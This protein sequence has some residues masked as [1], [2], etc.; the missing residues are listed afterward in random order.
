MRKVLFIIVLALAGL[1]PLLR[2][3]PAATEA[4]Q[5][6]PAPSAPAPPSAT[7]PPDPG[8]PSSSA[9]SSAGG[10]P[11][12]RIVDGSK[13]D[14]DFGPYQVRATFSAGRIIDVQM[15]TE[16]SDRRSRRIAAMAASSLRA[17]A[18]RAQSAHIDTVS[19]ATQTSEAYAQSLQAAIDAKGN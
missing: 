3:H 14:T 4:A 18:L 6:A 13:V 15:I 1:F 16:P 10:P 2:Y 8:T 12:A 17:E 5:S 9:P 19:G 7:A 11:S